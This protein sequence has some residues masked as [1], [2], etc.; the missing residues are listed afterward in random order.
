LNFIEL[1]CGVDLVDTYFD[2]P[3]IAMLAAEVRRTQARS[4]D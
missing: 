1:E 4:G 2:A 3:M